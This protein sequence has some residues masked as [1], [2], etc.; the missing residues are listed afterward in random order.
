[1]LSKHPIPTHTVAGQTFY[2]YNP[3]RLIR[4]MT[5]AQFV[6]DPT[7]AIRN[8]T[9]L[10]IGRAIAPMSRVQFNMPQ[11][12]SETLTVQATTVTNLK[13]SVLS[14]FLCA[15]LMAGANDCHYNNLGGTQYPGFSYTTD[16]PIYGS[17]HDGDGYIQTTAYQRFGTFEIACQPYDKTTV[18]YVPNTSPVTQ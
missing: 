1:M 14:R 18:T 7:T 9:V 12:L 6:A 16:G 3:E 17:I 10:P 11:L 4:N 8:A 2:I 13:S 15:T 5:K